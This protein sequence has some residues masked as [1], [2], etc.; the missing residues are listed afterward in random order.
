MNKIRRGFFSFSAVTAPGEHRNYNAWHLFDHVPE[1][2]GLPGVAHGQR[3]VC[4]P[5]YRRL[6]LADDAA[7]AALKITLEKELTRLSVEADTLTG[8]SAI[9]PAEAVD[10][11]A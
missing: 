10:A 9:M 1:N 6:R 7:L 3:W 8:Q 5:E 11:R 4:P 2:L